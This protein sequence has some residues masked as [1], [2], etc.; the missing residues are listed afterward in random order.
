MD[1]CAA[2]RKHQKFPLF[3]SKTSG[4]VIDLQSDIFQVIRV[5]ALCVWSI[6]VERALSI[7]YTYA[8]T[9]NPQ[10]PVDEERFTSLIISAENNKPFVFGEKV[11]L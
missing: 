9:R 11:L 1:I 6:H 8:T 2:Y 4:T 5:P 3:Y 7:W 10:F